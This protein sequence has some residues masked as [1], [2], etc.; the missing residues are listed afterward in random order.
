[1]PAKTPKTLG[2]RLSLSVPFEKLATREVPMKGSEFA[3]SGT[4]RKPLTLPGGSVWY[5]LGPN[6]GKMLVNV[7]LDD[8]EP[9][10][11]K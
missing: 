1:M 4:L 5:G 2:F 9:M 8:I 3:F 7:L 10:K 11:G 6:K